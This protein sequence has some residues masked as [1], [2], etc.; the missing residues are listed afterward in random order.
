VRV[1]QYNKEFSSKISSAQDVPH[2]I[3]EYSSLR[4]FE[5][6]RCTSRF[7]KE[8]CSGKLKVQ[9]TPLNVVKCFSTAVRER[10]VCRSIIKYAPEL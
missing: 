6:A 7:Y 3:V 8:F 5:G 4:E 9:V 10:N 2:V 1:V